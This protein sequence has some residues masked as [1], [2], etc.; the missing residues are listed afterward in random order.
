MSEIAESLAA[1]AGRIN[2]LS[3]TALQPIMAAEGV[4]SATFDLLSTIRAAGNRAHQADIARRL[5]VSPATLTSAIQ[6]AVAAGFLIQEDGQKDARTKRVKLTPK[7][8][9]VL[10]KILKGSDLVDEVMREG[11][12]PAHLAITSEVLKQAA[13]NLA[14][15][16]GE[17]P[18]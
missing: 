15:E 6:R 2:E 5:G 3:M 8:T 1:Q 10:K 13:A 7:A 18:E 14:R 9:M 4:T 12:D 11:L 16:T 17:E